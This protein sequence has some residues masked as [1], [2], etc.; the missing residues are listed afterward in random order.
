MEI[1]NILI[2]AFGD[3][4]NEPEAIRQVLEGF[5]Y[6]VTVKYIGRP[7]DFIDVLNNKLPFCF[8]CMILSCHGENGNII[9]P[10]LSNDIYEK[11]E[12]K[13]NFSHEEINCYN[14]LHEKLIV[15]LGCTTG[16]NEMAIAFSKTNN[17]YIAPHDYIEGNSALF[18]VIK[19]FYEMT[20][21]KK[22]VYDAYI[23][24]KETDKETKLF[25]LLN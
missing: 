2:V 13:S 24:S 23:S 12:P 6:F 22:S 4:G 17:T 21:N 5:N 8:D 25:N 9:M 11:G 3:T 1:K 10:V 19:F 18:F 15:N 7:N 14:H 16:Y 20:Q